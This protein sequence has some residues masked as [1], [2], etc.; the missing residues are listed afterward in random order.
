MNEHNLNEH[1]GP[2][3]HVPVRLAPAPLF[4]LGQVRATPQALACLQDLKASALSLLN[5]HVLGDWGD[6]DAQDRA[7]ND[8]ALQVGMRLMSSYTLVHTEA[9]PHQERKIWVI[10]EADRSATTVLLP[11]DY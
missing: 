2:L 10:T 7:H 11:D 3:A 5:R 6:L 1:E 4:A 9:N 8:L